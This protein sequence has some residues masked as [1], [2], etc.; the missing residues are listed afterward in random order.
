[1]ARVTLPPFIRSISGQIGNLH[2]RTSASG[3]TTVYAA[4]P[5]KRT[6]PLSNAE[7]AARLR[8]RQVAKTVALMQ[9]QGSQLS[10]HELWILASAAYD[11]AHK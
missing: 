5:R 4:T 3:K 7:K 1:M 8:F 2:F 11:A 6:K 9:H 10:R